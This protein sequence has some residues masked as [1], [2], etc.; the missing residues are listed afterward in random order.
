MRWLDVKITFPD[1]TT[2]KCG[3]IVT[4]D[5]GKNGRIQGAFRYTREYL[6][7]P[8]AFPLDPGILPLTPE[9]FLA[10]RPEGIHA[11]FEDALPDD[12]GRKLL[13][14]Q[15]G[16]KQREQ[17]PPKLLEALGC[18]GLGA[19][20]FV[21]ENQNFQKKRLPTGLVLLPDVLEAALRYDAGLSIDADQLNKL[22][23]HG[24]FPGGAR[25]KAAVRKEN[26]SYWLAKFPKHNDSFCVESLEAGCLKM[27][28]L[29]GLQ[30]P[31]FELRRF[32]RR[33]VLLIKRFDISGQ[34]GR[35]HMISMQTLLKAEGYYHLGYND[36]FEILRKY[37]VQ[38]SVDI[39]ALYRQMVFYAAIGNTDDHLKN[40]SM[41]H[42]NKG[43]CLSPIYDVVPDIYNKRE[44]T[45]SFPGGLGTLPPDRAGFKMIGSNLNVA[46]ADNII[47]DVL[48][49]VSQWKEI[50]RQYKVPGKDIQRLE[51]GINRRLKALNGD[52]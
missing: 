47:E 24:S 41:L 5:P 35:Y 29:S 36:L 18:N 27:A 26:G 49:A 6:E 46:R 34:G 44:H 39:P 12:W 28:V 30:V 13:I 8:R 51:W 3:E 15:A 42:M 40:F 48:A 37:A 32:D 16:L 45:L 20:S 21:P 38:P 10:Q 23:I 11:V 4:E 22:F 31:E 25:P 1:G 52:F 50:F 19:L 7:H 9:E 43:F 2:L 33:L 17:I 14:R